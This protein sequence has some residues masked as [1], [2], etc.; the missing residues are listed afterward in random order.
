M[1]S[2]D[3]PREGGGGQFLAQVRLILNSMARQPSETAAVGCTPVRDQGSAP[4]RVELVLYVSSDSPASLLNVCGVE[5][6]Q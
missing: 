6:N 5:P 1:E 2:P 3:G 4:P